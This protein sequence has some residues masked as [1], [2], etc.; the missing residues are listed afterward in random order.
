MLKEAI[1]VAKNKI[2]ITIPN[3]LNPNQNQRN[4][5]CMKHQ[6][7]LDA[8]RLSKIQNLIK[9]YEHTILYDPAFICIEIKK[10]G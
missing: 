9:N 3:G 6:W 10:R 7:V 8:Y 1:R 4:Y 5:A 2:L